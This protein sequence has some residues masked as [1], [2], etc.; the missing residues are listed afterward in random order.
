MENNYLYCIIGTDD[1]RNFGPMGIGGRGDVVTTIN[2]EN[3][4]AVI[5]GTPVIKYTLTRENLLAHQK[6]IEEVMKDHTVLPVRFCTVAES[7]EDIRRVLRK[8]YMEFKELLR[9]MDNMVEL[10]VKSLWKDLNEVFHEIGETEP[11]IK[12]LKGKIAS[13]PPDKCYADRINLGR[14]VQAALVARKEREAGYILDKL[15]PISRRTS[16]NKLHGDNM[17]LNA[18]FLVERGRIREF[19]ERMTELDAANKDRLIFKYVGPIPPFNF[20]NLVVEWK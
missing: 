19:D 8:R 9:D 17:N 5:S 12:R 4:A 14:M 7:V 20:V 13:V 1:A 10:G 3:I 15:K 11:E 18:A 16:V 6:V 2:C